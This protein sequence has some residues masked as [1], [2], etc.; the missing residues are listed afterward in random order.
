MD[1]KPLTLEGMA[2]AIILLKDSKILK[3]EVIYPWPI[4]IKPEL[5]K[6]ERKPE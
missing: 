3:C 1:K 4:Q 2:N 6:I 5:P